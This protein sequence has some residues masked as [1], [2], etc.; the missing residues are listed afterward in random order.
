MKFEFDNN[1]IKRFW[2]KIDVREN[3]ICW[4]WKLSKNAGGYGR[5]RYKNSMT[6][7]NRIA[8][9]IMYGDIPEGLCVLHKCDNP[10]C[11]N[12]KHLFVG[13]QKE[14]VLD[15]ERKGRSNHPRGSDLNSS[16]LTENDVLKIRD[17]Y[18][19]GEFTHLEIAKTFNVSDST[20]HNIVTGKTWNHIG[21]KRTYVGKGGKKTR[22]NAK[23]NTSNVKEIKKMLKDKR[24]KNEEIG[25]LFNVSHRTISSIRSGH[26]WSDVKH[27]K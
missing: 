2:D 13:T 6:V 9:A 20:V 14:N 10:A 22:G 18:S 19:K 1:F 5:V 26:T 17:L 7:S 8:Y 25:R 11:C 12:P 15:M 3:D 4:N 23:L 24:L 16:I 21:G 27:D